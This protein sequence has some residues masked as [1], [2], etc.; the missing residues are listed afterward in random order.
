MNWAKS[1]VLHSGTP[2]GSFSHSVGK[3]NFQL[4]KW[5]NWIFPKHL[6][7]F[8]DLDDGRWAA[9][10]S[11]QSSW[12]SGGETTDCSCCT[13]AHIQSFV[14]AFL[15]FEAAK[16][17]LSQNILSRPE[18]HYA[19]FPQAE[20]RSVGAAEQNEGGASPKIC[21]IR[22]NPGFYGTINSPT[23]P[24][25]EDPNTSHQRKL[26]QWEGN[27]KCLVCFFTLMQHSIHFGTHTPRDEDYQTLT[28]KDGWSES[29]PGLWKKN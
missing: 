5:F 14:T 17:K 4:R 10:S 9:S 8:R 1:V 11:N 15:P 19:T 26:S 21:C 28:W 25:H 12:A 29:W 3:L 22:W 20:R 7:V 27:R 24:V 2:C 16:R 6:E 13:N 18:R 23:S